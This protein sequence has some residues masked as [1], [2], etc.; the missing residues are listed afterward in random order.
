MDARAIVVICI[1]LTLLH[2][3]TEPDPNIVD[4]TTSELNSSVQAP[5]QSEA[6]IVEANNRFAL[7]LYNHYESIDENLFF[8]PYS[9]SSALTMTYEGARGKTAQ[10]MRTVLHLPDDK[11]TIRSDVMSMYAKINKDGPYQ[12]ATANALWAQTDYPFKQEYFSVVEDYHAGKV[13]N[14]DF[15]DTEDSR[16]TINEWVENKTT[17]KIKDLIPAG[18]LSPQTRLVLTNALYFKANWTNQFDADNTR[19]GDFTLGSGESIT[20]DMMHQTD[21]FEYGETKDIQI[22]EMDYRG[23]GLSM[24][25]LLPKGDLEKIESLIDTDRIAEWKQGM[26]SERVSVTLPKFRFETKYFMAQDLQEMGMPTAFDASM[27]DFTGMW[28]RQGTENLHISQ[29]IHQ[30]F[31]EVAEAGTEAAAATAVVMTDSTSAGPI[32]EPKIFRADHPF[33][34]MIQQDRTILFMGRMSNPAR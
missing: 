27:A 28:N 34:F 21:H 11:E 13:T 17:N 23:S 8:S 15:H 3:C 26:Q 24:L 12:L 32:E 19:E 20:T 10:E 6:S 31:V 30:T 7:D 33:I 16:L 25:I 2:G 18:V 1:A 22:L 9:I 4:P 5:P 29:V 14:L